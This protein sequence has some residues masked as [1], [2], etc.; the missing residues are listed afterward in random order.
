MQLF[1]YYLVLVLIQ[2]ATFML[3]FNPH[4][5]YSYIYGMNAFNAYAKVRA[6]KTQLKLFLADMNPTNRFKLLLFHAIV[7]SFVFYL[8]TKYI[9]Y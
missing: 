1:L 9:I 2:I 7:M 8:I 3:T 4:R 6:T 5:A